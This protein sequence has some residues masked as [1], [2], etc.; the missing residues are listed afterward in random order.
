MSIPF[1]RLWTSTRSGPSILLRTVIY[2]LLIISSVFMLAP[3]FWMVSTSLKTQDQVFRY[4]PILWPPQPRWMNYI[5]A[6]QFANFDRYLLNSVIISV[7]RTIGVIFLASLAGY[8]LAK[9]RFKGRKVIFYGIICTMMVPYVINIVPVYILLS[10]LNWPGPW[11]DSYW[12]VVVPQLGSALGVFLITQFMST[13]PTELIDA[14]R[15]DGCSE[16]KIYWRIAIP[17]AKPVLAALGI[18]IFMT[19]WN[20]FT[21]PLIVLNSEQMKTIP[22]GIATFRSP[23]SNLRAYEMAMTTLSCLPVFVVFILLRKQFTE[24]M[25]LTGI[26]G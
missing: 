22:L 24:G 4:P 15:I 7:T 26:K 19:T 9:L 17:L 25:T 8:A 20:D 1:K 12:G 2:G 6:W 21:W 3:F 13:L 14:A 5:E 18:L 23:W 10:K 11:L 16:F